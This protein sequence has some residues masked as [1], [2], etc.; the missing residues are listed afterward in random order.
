MTYRSP[1]P[2]R[3]NSH[4]RDYDGLLTDAKFESE[5]VSFPWDLTDALASGESVSSVAY[6][7]QSGLTVSA[8]SLATPVAT[9]T[10]TG[11][12]VL[13]AE[14]TTSTGRKIKERFA[15]Q[16]RDEGESDY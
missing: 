4:F 5:I 15:W 9:F 12:G 14:A 7:G 3:G 8:Y 6:D 11:T 13:E 16:A 1:I 10:I 2:S